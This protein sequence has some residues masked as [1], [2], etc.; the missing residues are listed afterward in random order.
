M[1]NLILLAALAALPALCAD[2]KMNARVGKGDTPR[3]APDSNAEKVLAKL[4]EVGRSPNYYWAWT[5]PWLWYGAKEGDMRFAEEKDGCL[6]PKPLADVKLACDYVSRYSDG[7]RALVNYMDLLSVVGTWQSPRYY[8]VNRASLTAAVQKQWVEF[9]AV[10]VFTWHMD[11]PYC[12]NGF[13]QASYRFTST[14]ANRNVVRQILDGT[15]DPCGTGTADGKTYR[16]A[17]TNPRAWFLAQLSDIADFFNGLNDPETG[18]PIPVILR[19]PHEAD[20]YWFWWG[21]TWCT[22]AELR[23]LSR[24]EADYLRRACGPDRILFAYTPD[25]NWRSFG[26][27][28]DADNTF[29]ARYPGDA[30]VD[31]LGIDDYSIGIGKTKDEAE[32]YL[33]EAIG[34]LRQM[35]AFASTRNQPVWISE[36]GGSG[37]RDDFWVYLHRAATAEGVS[38]SVVDVWCGGCGMMP[39]TPASAEDETAFA[40][41]P[42]VLMEGSRGASFR[43]DAGIGG[44][45]TF[46]EPM[47]GTGNVTADVAASADAAVSRTV[48]FLGGSITEM[49][50]FR[51]LVMKSLRARYPSVVFTEIAAG[52][53]STCSD[54]GA[55]RLDEDVLSKGVPDLLVVEFAVN[56]D[57]DGHFGRAR[58]VRGLEGVIR[59][60]RL[61][62][63]RA[64]I[65]VALF[66]N[67]GQYAQLRR[68]ETPLPYAAHAVVAAHY[69]AAV[70]DVGSALAASAAKD[71]FDWAGYR[72]CHPSPEGCQFAARIVLT[73]IERVFDP[74][75]EPAV[76]VL[77]APLDPASYFA[78]HV[79][80]DEAISS[81]DGGW[82]HAQPDWAK[83][84]G[85]VRRHD[86]VG[87]VWSSGRP[88]AALDVV[89]EGRT[90]AARMTN[91]PDA[92]ALEISVDG[93]PPRL[94]T[95]RDW[96]DLHY[97]SAVLLADDLPPGRHLARIV[98]REALHG[99]RRAS[100]LRIHRIYAN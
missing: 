29:L 70:A 6:R 50:G 81:S 2:A 93:E 90:L 82:T 100:T 40:R 5:D 58:C 61:A 66:V 36:S 32:R 95:F 27:E 86:A 85:H 92:G 76:K 3:R 87:K 22:S 39:E 67:E 52:L 4:R 88:G 55:F 1:K 57:Q 30:Y 77:P 64:E 68:G 45:G 80:P 74:L 18:R 73:A 96:G 26:R 65:V 33:K 42:C 20:G 35:T 43:A 13:P 41:R 15:G 10:M 83:I 78:S 91:G 59:R 38:C 75:G 56:D 97:P 79:V 17:F 62:N 94:L 69:G 25:R 98:V 12:T 8:A 11:H 84:P 24:L 48:A 21:D 60:L 23:A 14:G 51:P 71:G 28:G 31:I 44:P 47:A 7:R 9:G 46:F 53:S 37:K 89:F 19:Y 99:G 54:A 49:D 72:D 34:R 16:A 63:P